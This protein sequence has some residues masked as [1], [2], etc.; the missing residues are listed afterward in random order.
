L[1]TSDGQTLDNPAFLKKALSRLQFVQRKFSKHKGKQT[2]HKLARLHEKVANQ[3]MG[4]FY[5][6]LQQS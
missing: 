4:T 1:V 3:R 2:K 6:K 5:T